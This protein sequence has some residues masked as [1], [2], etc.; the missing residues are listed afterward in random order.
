MVRVHG[1]KFRGLRLNL[2]GTAS[3]SLINPASIPE[4][5]LE[6]TILMAKKVDWS[7]HRNGCKTCGKTQ[8]YLTEKEIVTTE[9]VNA[10]QTTLADEKALELLADCD[11]LIATKGTRVIRLNLK[12]E[13]PEDSELMAL[14]I[15]P[16]GKLRAPTLKVG[17][18]LLIGFDAAAY[19]EV[20]G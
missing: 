8:A 2:G 3:A 18:K 1:G 5:H 7:Y 13:R 14:M 4:Q 6:R 10:K 12:K 20:F 11:E 15:G 19:A 16:S 9:Q 17:R